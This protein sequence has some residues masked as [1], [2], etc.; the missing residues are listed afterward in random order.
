MNIEQI[1]KEIPEAEFKKDYFGADF[2]FIPLTK[3]K[4]WNILLKRGFEICPNKR[5]LV[6]NGVYVHNNSLISY[7]IIN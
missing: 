7:L 2:G 4:A 3:R 6:K 1:K 5:Y